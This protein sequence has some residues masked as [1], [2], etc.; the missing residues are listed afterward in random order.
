MGELV[1]NCIV[2][3]DSP[4]ASL[5]PMQTIL[6]VNTPFVNG[7]DYG[8][9]T[10]RLDKEYIYCID[11]WDVSFTENINTTLIQNKNIYKKSAISVISLLIQKISLDTHMYVLMPGEAGLSGAHLVVT[12]WAGCRIHSHRALF[13]SYGSWIL[14]IKGLASDEQII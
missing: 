6:K 7:N 8:K 14:G 2:I 3:T 11:T 1:L 4:Q 12:F 9:L 5:Q 10:T 13:Y